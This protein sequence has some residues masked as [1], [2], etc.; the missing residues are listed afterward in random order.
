MC[1]EAGLH[2]QGSYETLRR[3]RPALNG[4][5]HRLFMPRSRAEVCEL[6]GL[7]G[8]WG[9]HNLLLSRR[10]PVNPPWHEPARLLEWRP[11]VTDFY[12]R[13][14]PRRR[15]SW[16]TLRR[17]KLKSPSSNTLMELYSPEWELEILRRS[18][19]KR[20]LRGILARIPHEVPPASLSERV[21]QFYH[22]MLIN[23]LPPGLGT[24]P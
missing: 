16:N 5:L 11:V 19:G 14:W 24:E 20:S 15:G 2:F 12:L 17:L 4:D 22:A 8:S 1:R 9:F 13:R 23:L 6:V 21:Y 18:D 7:L 10:P 3:L